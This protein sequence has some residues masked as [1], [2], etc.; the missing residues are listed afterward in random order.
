MAGEHLGEWRPLIPSAIQSLFK[1]ASFPWWIAGG[2]AIDLYLGHKTRHHE[3]IDVQ[4]LRRDQSAVR[5][6]LGTW[7]VQAAHPFEENHNWPFREWSPGTLLSPEVH[8]IWCRP[9]ATE[10]WALQLMVADS[11]NEDWLYRRDARIRRPLHTIGHRDAAGIP[12]LAPEIQLLFKAKAPR[13]KDEADFLVALSYLDLESRAWLAQSI[14]LLHP[15]HPWL[16]S[17]GSH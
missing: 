9:G 7:D 8:D 11:S 14:R 3:D 4:V 10:P 6:L 17:L 5:R 13:P 16:V 1:D 2:W 12:Y 15:D